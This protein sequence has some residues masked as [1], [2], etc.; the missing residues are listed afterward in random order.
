MKSFKNSDW[1]IPISIAVHLSIING[2]LYFLTPQTYTNGYYILH[3]NISW[4]L[5]TYGL[6]Y[7]TRKRKERFF[8]NIQKVVQL[9]LIYGLAYFALFG[10]T[11]R[12]YKSLEHQ[13]FVYFLICTAL[14]AYRVF[15]F[16][17]RKKYRLWG[18][19][20]VKVVVI[21]RDKNLKKIRK[22]FDEPELGYRYMGYFDDKKS[23]SPT[24]LGPVMDSFL[25]ILENNI[26]EIYCVASKFNN[27]ELR[28]LIDFADN[29]LIRIKIIPDNK[30]IYSRG[31]FIE[32]YETVPVLNL[33]RVPLDTLF[34]R[35][36][37]RAFDL[38]FSS[39]VIVG[40]LSWLTPIMYIL[41]KLE[42]P[43]KLYF[44]QKR[45]GFKRKTFSCYKFRSM[46]PSSDADSKMATK[47]DMRVTRV[48]RVIRK[49]SI[50]ELPQFLNVFLGDMSVVGPRPHMESHTHDYEVSV[51]KYLVRHF[52]KPGITGLAQIK[53]Y[54]G[55]I[56]EKK[57]IL[58][59]TKLDIFYVEKW[60][61]WL[62]LKI[63]YQTIFNAIRG[64]EKAY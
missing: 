33:R 13:L 47:G 62:D 31:M 10:I 56:T 26:D 29:N 17:L 63:V 61:I 21:G 45:H 59:R 55:E 48:G 18:G 41:I 12:I 38:F 36:T 20:S 50:D 30:E 34:A 57:D 27:K 49:T 25:Y 53:G 11:G 46:T 37:K 39:L 23:K 1:V 5:I 43:G 7:Y 24:F 52:V 58:N 64:Q 60:T 19:N 35:V 54:R 51:D 9:Y 6:S 8:T 32:L 28:N 2:F 40:I 15:F 22:V 4:L 3:Y 42:S 14:T 16:W 44:K